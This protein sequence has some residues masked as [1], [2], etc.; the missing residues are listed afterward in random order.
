M[1]IQLLDEILRLPVDER[2]ELAENIW[3]SVDT[4]EQGV[5]LTPEQHAELN[6]R[7]EYHEK[8]PGEMIPWETA[9]KRYRN[10][11]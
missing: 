9:K 6:R 7:I 4:D 1:N 5:A 11:V 2:V 10:L 3:D 8:N